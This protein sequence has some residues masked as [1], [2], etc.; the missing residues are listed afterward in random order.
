[1]NDTH[2]TINGW[3]GTTPER[4]EVAGGAVVTTFRVAH[5]SRRLK[6][7]EW[8][9]GPTTWYQVKSWRR[10]AEHVAASIRIGDPVVVQGRLVA[11]VWTREDGATVAQYVVVA[12]SVGHDL[13]HGTAEFRKDRP[14]RMEETPQV[15]SPTTDDPSAGVEVEATA[16]TRS[17]EVAA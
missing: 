9:D 13:T 6:D 11:D 8:S 12:S 17:D 5:R 7:G 2:I 10:L 15:A 3:V 14:E 4:R 16:V 1:M